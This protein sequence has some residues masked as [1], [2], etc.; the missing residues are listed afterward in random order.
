[1]SFHGYDPRDRNNC[2]QSPQLGLFPVSP[3]VYSGGIFGGCYSTHSYHPY[4]SPSYPPPP[5]Q[6]LLQPSYPPPP[7]QFPSQPSYPPPPSPTIING[8]VFPHQFPHLS[9]NHIQLNTVAHSP[10]NYSCTEFLTTKPQSPLT[11]IHP[12]PSEVYHHWVGHFTP[13]NQFLP[14]PSTHEQPRPISNLKQVETDLQLCPIP[15]VPDLVRYS[16]WEVPIID[17]VKLKG[18]EKPPSPPRGSGEF[19]HKDFELQGH[20][21]HTD[22]KLCEMQESFK[23]SMDTFMSEFREELRWLWGSKLT[24][25]GEVDNPRKF[26]SLPSSTH[27]IIPA[28]IEVSSSLVSSSNGNKEYEIQSAEG[29]VVTVK[30]I[31][32]LRDGKKFLKKG[33]G[34]GEAPFDFKKNEEQVID[35]LEKTV[36]TMR[37]VLDEASLPSNFMDAIMDG[38]LCSIEAITCIPQCLYALCL[39]NNG[40]QAVKD[41][42]RC[43]VEVFNSRKYLRALTNDKLGE[44]MFHASSLHGPDVDM[45]I[46]ILN[47]ISNIGHRVDASLT[48]TAVLSSSTH[49]P[50]EADGE[51]RNI[52][53]TDYRE[54]S[55]MD[56][57]EQGIEPSSDSLVGYAELLLPGCVSKVASLLETVLQNGV[58]LQLFT[59]PLLS[60]SITVSP[61]IPVAFKNFTPQHSASLAL[62]VDALKASA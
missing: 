18:D 57:L 50:I 15:M 55:K 62:V 39:N 28:T 7:P 17:T 16:N 45:L 23:S 40:F 4:G 2:Y 29:A 60:L 9:A 44:L 30:S 53:M 59:L 22:A 42:L 19:S 58:V 3:A 54:S 36:V 31:G 12:H 34:E 52:V 38:V 11:P 61:S 56:S 35:E 49:V 14:P 32:K 33:H 37:K 13:T 24:P 43:L 26:G 51:E 6:Y 1:M 41:A 47:A 20:K 5:L 25:A 27:N 10:H 21:D 48:S 46:E 8:H